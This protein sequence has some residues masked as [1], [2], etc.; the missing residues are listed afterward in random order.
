MAIA[1]CAGLCYWIKWYGLAFWILIYA[2]V[3]GALRAMRATVK[4]NGL[5]EGTLATGTEPDYI[6]C[7]LVN[8]VPIMFMIPVAWRVGV[9]AGYL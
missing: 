6:T 1:L 3:Y 5:I 2:I 4:P 9:T 7:F 8:E